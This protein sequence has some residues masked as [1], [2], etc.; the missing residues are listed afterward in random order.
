MEHFFVYQTTKCPYCGHGNRTV[1][2]A[3]PVGPQGFDGMIFEKSVVNCNLDE[4][5]CDY[6]YV[7]EVSIVNSLN[8]SVK[9]IVEERKQYGEKK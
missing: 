3:I 1:F 4:G 9:E 6:N 2:Y 5:G 8:V 7:A